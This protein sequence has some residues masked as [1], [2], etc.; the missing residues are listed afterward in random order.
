[1]YCLIWFFPSELHA[2]RSKRDLCILWYNVENLF[3][4]GS[5]SLS[6]DRE[7]T[8]EGSRHWTFSRYRLKLT[9]LAKVILAAGAWDAPDL[10]GLCEVES[11]G[12]LKD[13]CEHP[14]LKSLSYSYLH[15]DSPD[16]RGMDVACLYRSA[17]IDVKEWRTI[18]S[19]I[20]LDG[21]RDMMHLSFCFGQSDTLELFLSHFVSKYR[22]AGATAESRR[23]QAEQLSRCVDSVHAIRPGSAILLAGDYND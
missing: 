1:M 14:L 12:V 7:F 21:T 18:A 4:P 17:R 3:F 16:H 8:P 11:A 23:I 13:L 5:D 19:V 6:V 20:K 22:G 10:V 2:Q 9:S 15:S